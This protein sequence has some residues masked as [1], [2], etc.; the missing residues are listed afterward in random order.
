MST[1]VN[2]DSKPHRI[3]VADDHPLFRFALGRILRPEHSGINVIGEARDG[4]E[5]LDLCRRL[6]P[7]LLTMDIRMAGMDGIEATHKI[8]EEF[9]LTVVLIVTA[10]EDEDLLEQALIAGASGYILKTASPQQMINA[11]KT[12]LAGKYP[13]NREFAM[14][15]LLR[16]ID[17]RRQ[18][19][20][21]PLDKSLKSR[22]L[23]SLT[24]REVD[25]LRL[26]AHGK[27]NSQIS[28]GLLISES[29]VKKHVRQIF[30]KLGV[31]DRL[32]AAI[33]ATKLGLLT[34]YY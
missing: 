29:T 17:E 26:L 34:D 9:P 14:R 23:E 16:L 19:D 6:R 18:K 33:Q 32:Q 8:K 10:F 7:E 13:V 2:D 5:A 15:L 3:I 27:S 20:P 24:P 12:A 30:A 1:Q 11:I 25:V 4:Q 21:T 31:T 22:L 28:Q